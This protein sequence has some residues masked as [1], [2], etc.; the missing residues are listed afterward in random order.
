LAYTK[1]EFHGPRLS[2]RA[3][4]DRWDRAVSASRHFRHEGVTVTDLHYRRVVRQ[5][6]ARWVPPASVGRVLKLD[7]Y[8][9]ATGT[10]HAGY[11]VES[12]ARVTGLDISFTIAAKAAAKCAASVRALQGDVR[13]LPFRTGAFDVVFSLGT[14]EHVQEPD[15]PVVIAELFRVLRPGGVCILAVNNRHSL[16]LTPLLFE[17]LELTGLVRN[18]WSYE[19]TY[20]PAH[21]RRLFGEAGFA[22]IRGDGTL[23]FPKW[24]RVFDMWSAARGGPA[25]AAVNRLKDLALA[26]VASAVERLERWGGL[27]RF[28]DQTV[29]V[30][31]KPC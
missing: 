10:T 30:G 18:E 3:L 25:F 23:L 7:L 13:D 22:Q 8:N 5:L 16:W 11:F 27:N 20:A 4:S 24:L 21:L 15:Q 19:P 2:A 6:L 31:V 14:L 29:T 26:P 1:R 28:A 12:G 9:E 17:L